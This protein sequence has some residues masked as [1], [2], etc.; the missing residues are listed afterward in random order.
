MYYRDILILGMINMWAKKASIWRGDYWAILLR[1]FSEEYGNCGEKAE[2]Y[3]PEEERW[4]VLCTYVIIRQRVDLVDFSS[5]DLTT[6]WWFW[7]KDGGC[8]G[9]HGEVLKIGFLI[10]RRGC[11]SGS[12]LLEWLLIATLQCH[13]LFTNIKMVSKNITRAQSVCCHYVGARC[14]YTIPLK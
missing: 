2:R 3:W 14:Y 8:A 13:N 11:R 7:S 4:K 9:N 5:G 1:F 10:W 12:Y 6:G